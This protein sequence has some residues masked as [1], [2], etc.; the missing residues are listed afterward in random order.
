MAEGPHPDPLPKG[1]GERE[2]GPHPPPH[3]KGEGEREEGPHPDPLP[4]GEGEREEVRW[5]FGSGP[6]VAEL[7]GRLFAVVSFVAWVSL[8]PREDYAML[9]RSPV[10]KPVDDAPVWSV[11]CFYTAQAARGSTTLGRSPA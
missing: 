2:E 8:G 11:I 3:P 7:F 10:M 6:G 1:E 5:A 4:N 9:A